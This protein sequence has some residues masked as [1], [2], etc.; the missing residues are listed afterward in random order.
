LHVVVPISGFETR[1]DTFFQNLKAFIHNPKT[2]EVYTLT[3]KH[4]SDFEQELTKIGL[5]FSRAKKWFPDLA[6]PRIYTFISEFAYQR[7]IFQDKDRDGLAIGL[8][9]FL[10]DYFDYSIL[11]TGSNSFSRYLTRT[12]NKDH[13][14]KK[15]LDAWLEDIL[16]RANGNRLVDEM[17]FNGTKMF[18]LENIMDA[19]DSIITEYPMEKLKWMEENEKEMWAFYFKNDWFY[20]TD[21]YVIKRLV[22]PAPNSVALRMPSA[23]PGQTGNYLGWK[24]VKSYMNRFPETQVKQLLQSDAQHI[25]EQSRYK[26]GSNK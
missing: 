23:A 22:N 7:L 19:P 24:I 21:Q 1:N 6:E 20:T 4:F 18:L 15:T 14:V 13:L 2:R 8:D 26:P 11:Q 12:Y 17:I 9:L 25:L 16:G 3:Q 5:G 10:D